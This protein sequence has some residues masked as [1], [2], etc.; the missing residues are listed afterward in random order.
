MKA[1]VDLVMAGHI[2]FPNVKPLRGI[3]SLS[4]FIVGKLL[5]QELGYKGVVIT[6]ALNAGA[7]AGLSPQTIAL[8][9]I[10]AG[11]DLLLEIGQTGMDNGKADLVTAYPAVLSPPSRRG[12]IGTRRLNE[13]VRRILRLK[14]RLGL[15]AHRITPPSRVAKVVGT[16]AHLAFADGVSNRSITLLKNSGGL[17]P[18][19]PNTGKKVPKRASARRPPRRSDRIW[20]RAVGSHR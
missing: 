18:L 4:P 16:P 5:R 19:T 2:V 11:D 15:A 12:D 9:A 7:L 8:G 6:D 10:R 14:W 1:G 3:S 13:S 20:S 17:L